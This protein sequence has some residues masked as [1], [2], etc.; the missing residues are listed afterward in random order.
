M[1]DE[2]SPGLGGAIG[3]QLDL[4]DLALR[5]RTRYLQGSGTGALAFEQHTLGLDVAAYKLFDIGAHGLGFGLRVG[6]DWVAQRFET[7]GFAPARD[8]FVSRVAPLLRAELALGG[9]VALN[10]DGGAE[11]T[12]LELEQDGA[13]SLEA[14]VTPVITFGF[15]VLLP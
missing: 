9:R 11:I 4:A 5:L 6:A 1:L 13:T 2:T 10:L 12:L 7:T 14:R 3:L 8:Q 15:G